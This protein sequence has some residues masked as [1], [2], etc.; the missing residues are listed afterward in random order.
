MRM[1]V[2]GGGEGERQAS[3]IPEVTEPVVDVV[4]NELYKFNQLINKKGLRLL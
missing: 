2:E 4:K 3:G 1:V